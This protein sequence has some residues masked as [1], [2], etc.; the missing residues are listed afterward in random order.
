MASPV[1]V[2]SH[3]KVLSE[4]VEDVSSLEAWERSFMHGLSS[5][6]TR[7]LMVWHSMV[8]FVFNGFPAL[9]Y[10]QPEEIVVDP[11]KIMNVYGITFCGPHAAGTIALARHAGL[12]ARGWALHGHVVPE[13][14]WDGGWH[15]LDSSLVTWFP[16]EDGSPAGV[17]EI[18]G[19]VK[20][21]LEGH[22]GMAGN[23]ERLLKLQ[24]SRGDTGWKEGPPLLVRS[25]FLNGS[26][27]YPARTH[28]WAST[29]LEYDGS[30]LSEGYEMAVS[31][32]YRVNNQLRPGQRLTFR[33]GNQGLHINM[34][35]P[36]F[37]NDPSR[38]MGEGIAAHTPAFGDM[39]PGRIGN[40]T[41][42]WDVPLQ[43]ARLAAAALRAE[44]L[45]H[46]EGPDGPALFA[47]SEETPGLVELRVPSSYVYLTGRLNLESIAGGGSTVT[48]LFSRKH[49]LDWKELAR[50]E[51]SGSREIDLSGEVF[52]LY[53]YRLRLL[54][55][56][57]GAGL[58]GIRIA[59]VF[60]HSQR[61]LPALAAG[62]NAVRFTAGPAEG[63]ITLEGS[64]DAGR[65]DR[66]LTWTE[67]RPEVEGFRQA[68]RWTLEGSRG[69][70]HV[71]VRTPGEMVRLRM[72]VACRL[73]QEGDTLDASVSWDGGE[74]YVSMGRCRGPHYAI[75][76]AFTSPPAPPGIR[77][78]LVRIEG[79]KV[80]ATRINNLRIDA[81]YA[82]PHG[83]FRP[84]RITTTWEEAGRSRSH[85]H[86][87]RSPA[88]EYSVTVG[89]DPLM[90]SLVL[91]LE[92][93]GPA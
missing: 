55:Q 17:Q 93:K 10:I 8:K 14:W 4:H 18:V 59:H 77:E 56:G 61:A 3:V 74:S 52:R 23:R 50:F 68:T 47:A 90:K 84:V 76:C 89:P 91:E 29:M 66:Q 24:K 46:E 83:G 60:Q 31:L 37:L 57:E 15:M 58:Q 48:V 70:I 19:E 54:L 44:N 32:G 21:W 34:N 71:P 69:T 81:D 43:E 16:R 62:E 49:G 51:E 1:G 26:G 79:R 88:E 5:E 78:A 41:L 28:N 13:I 39:A 6:E 36:R 80:N 20:A 87:A 11:I 75:T 86:V 53:D 27:W 42:E 25:P 38:R 67:L 65:R 64:L 73:R 45:R 2:V 92:G 9:E 30:L 33:W 63:T 35:E 85:V 22:P 12:R 72:S 7:G 82:E 40:G